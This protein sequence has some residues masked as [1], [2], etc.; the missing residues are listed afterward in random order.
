[1]KRAAR[2]MRWGVPAV[3]FGGAACV[4]CVVGVVGV[5]LAAVGVTLPP[6]L[7]LSPLF[8]LPLALALVPAS[9][10]AARALAREEAACGVE[11]PEGAYL[12]LSP[13]NA[14]LALG[15]AAGI[16][17]G[18][19]LVAKLV[20][21][22]GFGLAYVIHWTT[23]VPALVAGFAWLLHGE[24]NKRDAAKRALAREG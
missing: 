4:S 6:V 24:L 15:L 5:G 16:V 22:R 13:V 9:M 3:L 19:A 18:G 2:A 12:R 10:L 1:M 17:V 8:A 14:A 23:S 7:G 20:F 11:A 21:E